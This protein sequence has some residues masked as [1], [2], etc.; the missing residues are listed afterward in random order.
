MF[1]A[2]RPHNLHL[3]DEARLPGLVPRELPARGLRRPLLEPLLD[4][5]HLDRRLQADVP[6]VQPVD[7]GPHHGPEGAGEAAVHRGL[8]GAVGGDVVADA[9]VGVEPDAL[10]GREVVVGVDEAA[11]GA[12]EVQVCQAVVDA[13]EP[14]RA[15]APV[16]WRRVEG[17]DAI[18]ARRH[19]DGLASPRRLL[20]ARRLEPRPVQRV[21][22]QTQ[23]VP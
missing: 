14:Q 6:G 17:Y 20:R 21:R 4:G 11:L 5:A 9:D 7:P 3:V 15:R 2:V 18:P 10:L 23:V 13:A 16:E 8:D 12:L 1:P 22:L 19:A